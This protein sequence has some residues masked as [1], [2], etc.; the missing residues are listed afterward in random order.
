M[1]GRHMELAYIDITS[2][3]DRRVRVLT[4]SQPHSLTVSQS[5]SLALP[6]ICISNMTWR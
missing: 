6:Y 5:H 3:A 4:A 2:T 1:Y